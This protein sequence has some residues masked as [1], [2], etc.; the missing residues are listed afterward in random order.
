MVGGDEAELDQ[1]VIRQILLGDEDLG[2]GFAEELLAVE[3]AMAVGDGEVSAADDGVHRLLEPGAGEGFQFLLAALA[4]ADGVAL[5]RCDAVAGKLAFH[6]VISRLSNHRWA[7]S[8]ALA[9]S[10]RCGQGKWLSGWR[11]IGPGGTTS[12]HAACVGRISSG[13][14]LGVKSMR[15]TPVAVWQPHDL[16]EMECPS[17]SEARSGS[18]SPSFASMRSIGRAARPGFLAG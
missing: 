3:A 2:F 5:E 4:D 10:R 12:D 16:Q 1:L 17:D 7:G 8:S 18:L 15:S 6:A 14:I 11:V 9:A 13:F